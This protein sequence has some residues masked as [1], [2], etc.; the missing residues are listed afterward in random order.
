MKCWNGAADLGAEQMVLGMSHR[1]RLNV[2]VH[3]V[4]KSAGGRL[5]ALR[6]R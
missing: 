1:G 4:G 2:M 3:I 6:G 5:R